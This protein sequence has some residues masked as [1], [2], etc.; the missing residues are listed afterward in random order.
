[1]ANQ[2]VVGKIG[3]LTTVKVRANTTVEEAFEKAGYELTN[4]KIETLSGEEVEHDD[5]VEAGA[6][7]ILVENV[8]SG[9]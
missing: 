2:V 9:Y 5:E 7:Y 4:Q 6:T 3:S 1:M 8:K